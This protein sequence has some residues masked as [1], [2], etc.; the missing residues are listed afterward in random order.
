MQSLI[1]FYSLEGVDPY[2]YIYT[3]KKAVVQS[4]TFHVLAFTNRSPSFCF[5][6]YIYVRV[7][8]YIYICLFVSSL[9]IHVIS[10]HMIYIYMYITV[11]TVVAAG[12]PMDRQHSNF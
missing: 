3:C 7:Y 8:I 9:N 5:S 11:A 1:G 12:F 2:I 6:L 4:V 10:V